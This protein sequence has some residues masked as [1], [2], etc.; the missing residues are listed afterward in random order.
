MHQGGVCTKASV[1]DLYISV[2]P[3]TMWAVNSTNFP[4]I[5]YLT[6]VQIVKASEDN[7]VKSYMFYN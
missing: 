1:C 4:Q 3:H 7:I 5:P 2:F 6:L